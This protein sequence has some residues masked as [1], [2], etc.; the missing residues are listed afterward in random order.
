MTIRLTADEL[1]KLVA[2]EV[3]RR[4]GLAV[5]SAS[6]RFEYEGYPDDQAATGMCADLPEEAPCLPT[7]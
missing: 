2:A 3:Q 4:T 7:A 5:D 1:R 6:V